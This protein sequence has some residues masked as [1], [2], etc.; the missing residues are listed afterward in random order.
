LPVVIVAITQAEKLPW[1]DEEDPQSSTEA[2]A[3]RPTRLGFLVTGSLVAVLVL[4]AWLQTLHEKSG[5]LAAVAAGL[6]IVVVGMLVFLQV[7]ESG[8]RPG[9]DD[10]PIPRMKALLAREAG[11]LRRRRQHWGLE[12]PTDE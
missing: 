7:W 5:V 3:K 9:A 4:N 12:G 8:P 1:R 2:H 6:A 10:A 11:W